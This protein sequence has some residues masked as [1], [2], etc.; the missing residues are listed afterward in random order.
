MLIVSSVTTA[1]RHADSWIPGTT[2][3]A[4]GTTPSEDHTILSRAYL[5]WLSATLKA[6]GPTGA[7]PPNGFCSW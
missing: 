4:S 7:T 3:M 5:N 2:G 6:S 1:P